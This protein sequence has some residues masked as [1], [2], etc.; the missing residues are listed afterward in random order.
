MQLRFSILPIELVQGSR[1]IYT[2]LAQSETGTVKKGLKKGVGR[3]E[4]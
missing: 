3:V 2:I 4:G 1:G